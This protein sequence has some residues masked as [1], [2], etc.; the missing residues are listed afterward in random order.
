MILH[1]NVFLSDIYI[2]IYISLFLVIFVMDCYGVVVTVF[3]KN[4]EKSEFDRKGMGR[5]G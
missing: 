1:D 2:Y 3:L 4:L 5:L